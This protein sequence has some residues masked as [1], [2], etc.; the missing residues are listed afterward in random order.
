MQGDGG[1]LD[2]VARAAQKWSGSGRAKTLRL[3]WA[4]VALVASQALTGC[5]LLYRPNDDKIAQNVFANQTSMELT[6][7]F[8]I[9]ATAKAGHT[10]DELLKAI[11]EELAKLRSGGVKDDEL[12]R[13]KTL[14]ISDNVFELERSSSRANQLNDYNHFLGD[15]NYLA[16]DIA[17]TN[18]ATTTSVADAART[19]LKAQDRVVTIVTPK[20][21]A[22]TPGKVISIKGGA[23]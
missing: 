20:K 15:P 7:Y 21:E 11:D 5:A 22:P 13:A 2:V 1:I 10:A 16:K 18:N 19:Y 4:C 23:K 9:V 12:M 14:V 17:R 6:S 3:C 8:D